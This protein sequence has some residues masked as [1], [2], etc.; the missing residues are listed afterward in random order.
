MKIN[1][2]LE[3]SQPQRSYKQK[4]IDLTSATQNYSRAPYKERTKN[5]KH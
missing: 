3:K 1:L 5:K 2:S 4:Y